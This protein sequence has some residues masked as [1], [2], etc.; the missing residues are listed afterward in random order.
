M[1]TYVATLFAK[2][3]SEKEVTEFY[4][5]LEPQLRKAPGFRNRTML[6]AK[7]GKLFEVVKPM[8]SE[9]DLASNREPPHP[10]GVQF[11]MI[12]EWDTEE[13]RVRFSRS[14]DKARSARLYPHLHG[15]HTHEFYEDVTPKE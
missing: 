13:D 11:V 8:L 10:E 14:Q 12:E 4:Q 2:H 5:E 3:G 6:R 7:P 1:V 9:E 15:H